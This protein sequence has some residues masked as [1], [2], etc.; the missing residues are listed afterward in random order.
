MEPTDQGLWWAWASSES[1]SR[2]FSS[3]I[4]SD[5]AI[6]SEISTS[7]TQSQPS[8]DTHRFCVC[9]CSKRATIDKARWTGYQD[10][11]VYLPMFDEDLGIWRWFGGEHPYPCK[12][13]ENI[14]KSYHHLCP[15]FLTTSAVRLPLLGSPPGSSPKNGSETEIDR[16][17]WKETGEHWFE[18]PNRGPSGAYDGESAYEPYHAFTSCSMQHHVFFFTSLHIYWYII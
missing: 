11:F 15:I 4:S 5:F 13:S 18:N 16:V 1:P 6:L 17:G 10:G 7:L 8:D 3:W 9:V 2:G 12:S 14:R